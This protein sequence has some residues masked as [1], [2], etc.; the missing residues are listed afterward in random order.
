MNREEKIVGQMNNEHRAILTTRPQTPHKNR[1]KTHT[2]THTQCKEL[3]GIAIYSMVFFG[4]TSNCF[5]SNIH[6]T[7]YILFVESGFSDIVWVYKQYML[8]NCAV[9]ML[10][11]FKIKCFFPKRCHIESSQMIQK[12][13]LPISRLQLTLVYILICDLKFF[14]E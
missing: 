3:C 4:G 13:L 12:S 10:A 5:I 6:M 2:Q 11:Q 9:C 1:P 8:T 7:N 14:Q